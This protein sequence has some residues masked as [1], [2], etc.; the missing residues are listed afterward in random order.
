MEHHCTFKISD[1]QNGHDPLPIVLASGIAALFD[2]SGDIQSSHVLIV[3]SFP[4]KQDCH[5]LF[6]LFKLLLNAAF[7]I[8]QITIQPVTLLLEPSIKVDREKKGLTRW[9]F[10]SSQM[11]YYYY[12][13]VVPELFGILDYW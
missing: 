8:T 7:R 12:T 11:R 4:Y 3:I 2:D 1:G 13:V 10:G 9:T 6:D 5:Y